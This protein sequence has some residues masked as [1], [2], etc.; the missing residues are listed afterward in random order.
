MPV[1]YDDRVVKSTLY[2]QAKRLTNGAPTKAMSNA[3]SLSLPRHCTHGNFANV[4]IPEKMESAVTEII[5]LRGETLDMELYGLTLVVTG[6][7]RL[8]GILEVSE[9][10]LFVVVMSDG[11]TSKR[12]GDED[13]ELG[14][15]CGKMVKMSDAVN[16]EDTSAR[17]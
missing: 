9:R 15:H 17:S 6:V 8:I 1:S 7:D 16:E 14:S 12:S 11:D 4:V 2:A 3:A 5:Q 10:H 13:R